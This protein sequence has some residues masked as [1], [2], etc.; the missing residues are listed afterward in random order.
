M[1]ILI[2]GFHF[3]LLGY[4]IVRSSFFPTVLEFL[5]VIPGLTA[6]TFLVPSVATRIF[7]YIV[8]VGLLTDIALTGWL[9]AAG[10]KAQPMPR[11]DGA[12]PSRYL[13]QGEHV[14]VGIG[15]CNMANFPLLKA[16]KI[17]PQ[18]G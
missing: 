8:A 16:S 15:H 5:A 18:S 9:L 6:M 2:F 13:P 17:D 12:H 1:V 7:P 14:S 10:V 11:E 3:V 4:L